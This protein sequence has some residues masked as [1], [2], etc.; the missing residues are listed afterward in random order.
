MSKEY[1]GELFGVNHA[2]NNQVLAE[3]KFN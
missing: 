1:D 3:E 2:G